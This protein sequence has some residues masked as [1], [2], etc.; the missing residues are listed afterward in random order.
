MAGRGVTWVTIT[1][2][3]VAGGDP[4]SNILT[5]RSDLGPEVC[6]RWVVT[7][8]TADECSSSSATWTLRGIVAKGIDDQQRHGPN[9]LSSPSSRLAL[10]TP[11]WTDVANQTGEVR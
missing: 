2:R 3:A 10:V 1:R 8:A 6:S 4:D 9:C 7:T 11:R 5:S